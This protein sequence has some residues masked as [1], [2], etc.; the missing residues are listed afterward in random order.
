VR[1]FLIFSGDIIVRIVPDPTVAYTFVE[2]LAQE[3][4][5]V[6]Y[7]EDFRNIIDNPFHRL[8]KLTEGNEIKNPRRKQRG[9]ND[10]N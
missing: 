2:I 10:Q 3:A 9:I 8:R 1:R 5:H 7:R 4:F 6:C